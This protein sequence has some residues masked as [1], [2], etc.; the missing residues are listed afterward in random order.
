MVSFPPFASTKLSS[1]AYSTIS[2]KSVRGTNK[3]LFTKSIVESTV[4]TPSNEIETN[5]ISS[6]LLLLLMKK[7]FT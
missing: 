6:I 4:S 1:S 7:S 5:S 3:L 2:S